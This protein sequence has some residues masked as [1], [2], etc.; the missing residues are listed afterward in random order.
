MARL[1]ASG[2]VIIARHCHVPALQRREPLGVEDRTP[3]PRHVE[4]DADIDQGTLS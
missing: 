2:T 1:A 3:L 4:D